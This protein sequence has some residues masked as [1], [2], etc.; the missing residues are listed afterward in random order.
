MTIKDE[1][2]FT[3]SIE[4][5]FDET[6]YT[7]DPKFGLALSTSDILKDN[8]KEASHLL[9]EFKKYEK[10]IEK[11]VDKWISEVE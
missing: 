2:A 8:L 10:Y 4:D 7:D 1:K 11:K 9:L 3:G 5:E 6:P